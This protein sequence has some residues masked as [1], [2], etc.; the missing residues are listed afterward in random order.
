MIGEGTD[1]VQT[2]PMELRPALVTVA[3]LSLSLVW[4]PVALAHNCT[5]EEPYCVDTR[6]LVE[7]PDR[8]EV[9]SKVLGHHCVMHPFD[10][11][12]DNPEHRVLH[13]RIG[14]VFS[15]VT[16][17]S[18]FLQTVTVYFEPSERQIMGSIDA[19]GNRND[20][21][22]FDDQGYDPGF[23]ESFQVDKTVEFHHSPNSYT[24]YNIRNYSAAAGRPGAGPDCYAPH[25][26]VLVV[27]PPSAPPCQRPSGP[28]P[29]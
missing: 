27:T 10:E 19:Y 1:V 9:I 2:A 26:L 4:P 28:C 29:T 6:T 12:P 11:D 18:G 13:S 21:H 20:F 5:S 23:R 15:N 16:H 7:K 24:T 3:L 8:Q 22:Q 25:D 14:V 17:N